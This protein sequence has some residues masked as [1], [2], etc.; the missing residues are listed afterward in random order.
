MKMSPD[1]TELFYMDNTMSFFLDPTGPPKNRE[2][3]F[4]TQRFSRSLYEALNRITEDT[5]RS[6][7]GAEAGAA[8]EILTPAEIAALLGRRNVVKHHIDGLIARY[9]AREVLY[10]P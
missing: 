9:G 2:V 3:F 4:R 10:F 7:L 8:H 6:V 1:G 5:L